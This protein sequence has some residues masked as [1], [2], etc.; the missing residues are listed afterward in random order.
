M[1]VSVAGVADLYP[2]HRM[3]S[4]IRPLLLDLVRTVEA[5]ARTGA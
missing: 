4:E 5:Q 3:L 1:V 2:A